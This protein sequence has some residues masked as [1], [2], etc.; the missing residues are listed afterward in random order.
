MLPITEALSDAI[1]SGENSIKLME[2]AKQE[3]MINLREA[4]LLK[5]KQGTT[6]LEEINRITK[7]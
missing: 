2:L 4:G 6:S 7:D 1:L 3:G 5:V